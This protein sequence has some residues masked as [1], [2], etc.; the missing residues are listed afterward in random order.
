MGSNPHRIAY[1]ILNVT[2]PATNPHIIC[3]ITCSKLIPLTKKG[4]PTIKESGRNKL[5]IEKA[6][7]NVLL[8]KRFPDSYVL[9]ND[10]TKKSFYD[11]AENAIT[12]Y[13]K[14]IR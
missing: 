12:T 10:N 13:A 5:T 11:L 2:I 1:L 6:K 14:L 3:P 9:F 7:E 8:L 4:F